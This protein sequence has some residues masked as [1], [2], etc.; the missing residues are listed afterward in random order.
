MARRYVRDNRGRFATTGA[1]ARG[2]RL[3]TA[4]GNKRA[5]VTAKG[6]AGPRGTISKPK[7]LRPGAIKPQ[8]KRSTPAAKLNRAQAKYD[9]AYRSLFKPASAHE[10]TA[11][12]LK[13]T[14]RTRKTLATLAKAVQSYKGTPLPTAQPAQS[15]RRRHSAKGPSA[16]AVVRSQMAAD[17]RRT[18][19]S[20]RRLTAQSHK[21]M[22]ARAN[23]TSRGR[24]KAADVEWAKIARVRD[25]AQE[26]LGRLRVMAKSAPKKSKP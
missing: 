12:S 3:K 23:A 15:S 20:V 2:G 11:T 8:P 10:T 5:T 16:S 22:E 6:P 17:L 18:R 24:K 4:A 13:R 9:N 14:Q 25:Q 21:A 19:N 7:G 26:A 1:T